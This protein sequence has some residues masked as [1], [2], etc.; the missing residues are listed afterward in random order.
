MKQS[1][2]DRWWEARMG[3]GVG[4]AHEV[5]ILLEKG[6]WWAVAWE[7]TNWNWNIGDHAIIGDNK[8]AEAVVPVGGWGG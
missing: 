8:A 5:E 6:S 2:G 3:E 4:R 1:S 7:Q